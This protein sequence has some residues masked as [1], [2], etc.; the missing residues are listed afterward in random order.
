MNEKSEFQRRVEADLA[1]AARVI[2]TS[3]F[4]RARTISL[5]FDGVLSTLVLGRAWEKARDR[6]KPVPVITPLVHGI[7]SIAASLT[8]GLRK[9]FPQT[10]DVLRRLRSS[11][12]ALYLLTSRRDEGIPAAERWLARYGLDDI[13][14]RTFFNT[15]GEDADRFKA[16]TVG[17]QAIDVHVDDDSETLAHLASQ[18]P[19]KLFVHMNCYHR[20]SPAAENVLVVHS[21][22]EVPGIFSLGIQKE[23]ANPA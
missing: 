7:K 11:G 15:A 18:F 14:E 8:E 23:N 22:A 17:A 16:R 12:R 6:K 9:P 20:K 10:E 3:G 1:Q 13:F 19:D 21:W 2:E 5:D 4:D